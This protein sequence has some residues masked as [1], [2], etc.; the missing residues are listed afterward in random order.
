MAKVLKIKLPQKCIGCELC[1][2][3]AQRQLER[4]G[5]D[6]SPIRVFRNTSKA[7]LVDST[8]YVI[9]LDSKVNELNLRNLVDICPTGVFSIEDEDEDEKV[10]E[11]D[12]YLN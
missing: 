12:Q 1:V 2:F 7:S 10:L 5:F 6:D 8:E 9:E 4:V 3:E 11:S